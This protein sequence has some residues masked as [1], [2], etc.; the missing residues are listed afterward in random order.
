M[1]VVEPKHIQDIDRLMWSIPRVVLRYVEVSDASSPKALM[2]AVS[3]DMSNR[4]PDM[5]VA[6][7]LTHRD[8]LELLV[9]YV[10]FV[11]WTSFTVGSLVAIAHGC[12]H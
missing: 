10:L 11:G 8:A 1:G 7:F 5:K 3:R 6:G 12:R 2:D 4:Y 9:G